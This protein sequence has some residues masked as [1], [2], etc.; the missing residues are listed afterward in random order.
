MMGYY[1]MIWQ[2]LFSLSLVSL[3]SCAQGFLARPTLRDA[4]RP[5]P[6]GLR[7]TRSYRT[8]YITQKIDHFGFSEDR[9]FKQ[10]YLVVDRHW[11]ED[12]GSVLFY[13]GNEGDITWFANN[14]GF[15]W[16]IAEELNAILVFAEHR[17]YGES[18]PF[19]NK[20]FSDVK[21]LNYLTSEQA[22]ADFA[23][24]IQHLKNTVPG[25]LNTPVI[26]IGGSYGGMLAAWLRM[27]YPNIVI[28]ALAASAP[29]WQ[30]ENLVPCGTF[31]RIV[32][33]DFRKSGDCCSQSIRNSWA[34]INRLAS[35]KEG[36]KWLS[37]AFHLCSPLKT[38]EDAAVFKAWLSETWVNLA[39]VD[40]PYKAD[41]L[42]PLPAWP[43][44]VACK[45][46][47]YSKL[48]DKLLLQNIFQ[49]VNI[50]YNYTG[51][52]SCFNL[53]QTATKS[54]GLQGWSYQACTEM[55]MPLCSDGIS[56]MFEPQKWD[57]HAYSEECFNTW[58]VKPRALWI[59]TLYG[60]KNISAHSN[61]IF[62]NGGLDPWSG[63]GVTH[64][65]T[66]TLVAVVIPEGAHHLDL[67]SNS[68]FDPSSVLQ[69]RLLEVHYMKL[70]I[71][72]YRANKGPK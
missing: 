24:L 68:P 51:S 64:N 18:L 57:L 35:S 22:L 63:G 34:A 5:D 67:R 27:K 6:G 55:V 59:P 30:F 32:T 7:A 60:G 62:S 52:T 12:T 8:C 16:N 71:Q 54:L 58:G 46:L 66:D 9:T 37:S 45:Y 19:G 65:I 28:G 4:S 23:V 38:L 49:A 13:T 14:T 72:Q 41:F 40:Y 36:L 21:Y 42:E 47:K 10:R 17:Y 70:W 3:G 53:S 11:N 26:A 44:E 48:P 39:M 20:T 15:M 25:I 61:I 1:K 2:V 50:Y 43:I 29:I 31:Y 69:A 56:D 33:E